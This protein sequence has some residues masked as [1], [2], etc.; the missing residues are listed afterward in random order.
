MSAWLVH[1]PW[2]Y[3][4][5]TVI[6]LSMSLEAV[7]TLLHI[8]IGARKEGDFAV[9]TLSKWLSLICTV[10]QFHDIKCITLFLHIIAFFG[11]NKMS[12]TAVRKYLV[13]P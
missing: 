2:T 4:L 1:T 9:F 11:L 6:I 7:M 3:L 13:A 5:Q 10:V 12:C 8:E